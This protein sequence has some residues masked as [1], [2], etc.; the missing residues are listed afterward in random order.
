MFKS[1]ISE[2]TFKFINVL[3]GIVIIV[4]GIMLGLSFLELFI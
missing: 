1:R 3:C 2:R 4:Y